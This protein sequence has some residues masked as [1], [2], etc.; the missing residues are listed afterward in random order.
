MELL[1]ATD[2]MNKGPVHT[3]VQ[4]AGRHTPSFLLGDYLEVEWPDLM[5]VECLTC[6]EGGEGGVGSTRKLSRV[7]EVFI[8]LRLVIVLWV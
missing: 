1:P 7:T 2:S 4:V 6:T 8:I 5:G 3:L